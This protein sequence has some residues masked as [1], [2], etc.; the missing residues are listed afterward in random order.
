[1][2]YSPPFPTDVR[3]TRRSTTPASMPR[4]SAALS[5][6][7]PDPAVP[8]PAAPAGDA[9]PFAPAGGPAPGGL[10]ASARRV[11]RTASR[12]LDS[13]E[14]VLDPLVRPVVTA[15]QQRRGGREAEDLLA[16]YRA[17]EY[18]SVGR[19]G[20][21][22]WLDPR[23]RAITPIA[24][25]RVPKNVAR[26]LRSGRFEVTF[27]RAFP[28]V[29]RHCATIDGRSTTGRPWLTPGLQDVYQRLHELGHAHSVEVWREG[30]LVGGELGVALGGLYSGESMFYLETNA[31]KVALA[32]LTERL[33]ARGFVLFD[34]QVLTEVG[35]QFGA[36]AIPRAEYHRRLRDALAADV[37]FG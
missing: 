10:R 8:P 22:E 5:T 23:S 30:R 3:A 9:E 7:A 25:R 36:F 2:T 20:R 28:D 32:G 1:M 27:D 14:T 18:L 19:W 34:T 21:F 31:S 16:H 26:V 33:Q 12:A 24:E 4:Q 15:V 6:P 11:R 13:A 17:A 35:R 29:V 37:T